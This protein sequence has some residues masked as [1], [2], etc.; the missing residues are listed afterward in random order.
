M[1]KLKNI[2]L[3]FFADNQQAPALYNNLGF[4]ITGK[5]LCFRVTT[6][7]S[8]VRWTNVFDIT[9]LEKPLQSQ[10]EVYRMALRYKISTPDICLKSISLQ[11]PNHE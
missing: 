1:L 5:M 3:E 10:R 4:Q 6:S 8:F 2:H 9:S 7:D 11:E